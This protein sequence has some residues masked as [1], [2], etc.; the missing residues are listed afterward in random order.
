VDRIKSLSMKVLAE[1]KDNFGTDFDENKNSL[2]KISTIT[3]KPLRNQIAGYITR[4]L[5][6]ELIESEKAKKLENEQVEDQN[7]PVDLVTESPSKE[8]T[9]TTS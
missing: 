3:S 4:F 1:H 8:D 2:N 5:K 7:E 9:V 6:N